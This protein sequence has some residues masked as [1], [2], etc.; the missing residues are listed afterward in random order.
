MDIHTAEPLVPEPSLVEVE[1]AIRKLKSYKSPGADQIPAELIKAG[2]EILRSE[3]LIFILKVYG[4][5]RN[6]HSSERNLLLYQFLKGAIR[7]IVIIIEEGGFIPVDSIVTDLLP[8]R[9]STFARYYRKDWKF[10][11]TVHQLFIDFKKACDRLRIEVLYNILLELFSN[12]TYSKV[13]V[14][15]L[16]SGKFPIQSGQKQRDALSPLLFNFVLEY[17]IRKVQGIHVGLEYGTH[18]LLV[19]ADDV[20]LLGDSVNTIRENSETLLE[21]SRDAGLEINAQKTKCMIMPRHQNSGQN[22]NIR[23]ANESFENVAK[24]KYLGTT[25]T[26]QNDIHGEIKSRLNSR[27]ACYQSVQNLSSFRVI[28]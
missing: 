12:E 27:T 9:F 22:Q 28:S 18:Q 25:L 2:G 20:S 26:D 16:L 7:L 23:T 3:I 4:I 14:G 13:R 1:I 11:G 21:A 10:N 5:M 17:A 19:Y 8:V 15:K 6:C 24:F